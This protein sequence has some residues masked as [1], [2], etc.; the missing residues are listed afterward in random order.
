M[1]KQYAHQMRADRLDQAELVKIIY[2]IKA[3]Y[4]PAKAEDQQKGC[5]LINRNIWRQPELPRQGESDIYH[6][7]IKDEDHHFDQPRVIPIFHKT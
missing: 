5:N 2:L 7:K 6:V 1:D 3:G 4:N